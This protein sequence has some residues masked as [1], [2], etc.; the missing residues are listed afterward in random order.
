MPRLLAVGSELVEG[1][2]SPG[3]E[4]ACVESESVTVGVGSGVGG[5]VGD[6][7]GVG[8]GAGVG[9]GEGGGVG[10][11][12]AGGGIG[13]GGGGW[14]IASGPD[15]SGSAGG[16]GAR[17]ARP[18]PDG[19]VDG[20][21]T[22]PGRVDG[23]TAGRPVTGSGTTTGPTDGVGMNGVLLSGSAVL[24]TVAEPALTAAR[25]GIEAVPASRA[26]VKRY[27]RP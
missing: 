17:G 1:P 13:A 5:S 19:P 14:C 15:R 11:R 24:P 7:T 12:G 21:T 2:V 25:I 26:T 10:G 22:M 20:A 9:L 8:C 6:G 18:G 16:A 23:I 3:G 4:G 27:P